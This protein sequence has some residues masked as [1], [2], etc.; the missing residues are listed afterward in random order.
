[1]GAQ[2]PGSHAESVGEAA[3]LFTD[4]H[5]DRKDSKIYI[6]TRKWLMSKT[7]GGCFVCGGPADLTHPE[8][9][10]S[11]IGLEDHHG[12]GL[13]YRGVLFAMNLMPTEWSLGFAAKPEIVAGYVAMINVILKE[14]G[15]P[16]YDRPI[17]TTD[18]VM[19]WVDDVGNASIKLDRA[20]HIGTQHQ[21]TPD[22]RGFEAVGIHEI[23]LPIWAGQVTCDFSR[24]DMWSGTTGTIAVSKPAGLA[25][26]E[27][28]VEHV[29][30]SVSIIHADGTPLRRGHVLPAT[31]PSARVAHAGVAVAA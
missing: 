19:A 17:T 12:G 30:P 20:H 7:S 8:A 15:E 24:F 10:A 5:P 16:T 22:A 25:P 13:H 1:M 28:Q 27:V 9:P 26:G 3:H 18:E 6:A 4:A 31:H 11:A 2:V 14:L 23:P 21:H 29:H